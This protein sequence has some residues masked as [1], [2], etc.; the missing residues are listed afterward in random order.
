MVVH[1]GREKNERSGG[2]I[3]GNNITTCVL[4]YYQILDRI[5][6]VKLKGKHFN[7]AI[8]VVYAPTA[9][10]T[11]E[12]IYNFYNSMNNDKCK[13]QEITIIMEDLNVKVG[14]VQ[15]G[16]IVVKFRLGS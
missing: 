12:K 4:D 13:L 3:L 10:S 16:E 5:L 6:L 14:K 9:Q 1:S 15:E 2:L 8:I 7:I 11:E